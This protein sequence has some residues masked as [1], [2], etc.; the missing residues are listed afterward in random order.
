MDQLCQSLIGEKL[1]N[2]QIS[3]QTLYSNS[4][5]NFLC[6]IQFRSTFHI[7]PTTPTAI[8]PYLMF[9]Y[10]YP[11]FRNISYLSCNHLIQSQVLRTTMWTF[12]KLMLLMTIYLLEFLQLRFFMPFLSPGVSTRT[13]L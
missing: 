2:I 9:G 5:L 4:V 7:F 11:W 13:F 1:I 8:F 12:R 6:Q 10:F 3:D